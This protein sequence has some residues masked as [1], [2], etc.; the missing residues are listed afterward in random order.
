M[1]EICLP[2]VNRFCCFLAATE[3]VDVHATR[4]LPF[5]S[6]MLDSDWV[7]LSPYLNLTDKDFIKIQM[8]Y[9]YS[10]DQAR[11]ALQLWGQSRAAQNAAENL[12][13]YL[14]NIGRVDIVARHLA[15]EK[16]ISE[17]NK[18]LNSEFRPN[19]NHGEYANVKKYW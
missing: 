14:I 19:L 13:L 4:H 6:D 16:N 1:N 17:V 10:R 12:R 8:E 5:I 11:A 3:D 15:T 2:K 9:P 7:M 18:E